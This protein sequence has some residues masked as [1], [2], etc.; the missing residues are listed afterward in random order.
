MELHCKKK[1]SRVS[2]TFPGHNLRWN[3]QD[4]VACGASA[5]MPEKTSA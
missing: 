3:S 2:Y 1:K 4:P 5:E